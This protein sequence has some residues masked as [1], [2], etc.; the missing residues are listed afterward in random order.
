MRQPQQKAYALAGT[1]SVNAGHY[2]PDNDKVAFNAACLKELN[3]LSQQPVSDQE[4]DEKKDKVAKAEATAAALKTDRDQH[5]ATQQEYVEDTSRGPLLRHQWIDAAASSILGI[6]ALVIP[7]YLM[8][9]T[10]DEIG[11]EFFEEK[12]AAGPLI[13]M[14]AAT[15]GMAVAALRNQFKFEARERY[16]TVVLGSTV[17]TYLGSLWIGASVAMTGGGSLTSSFSLNE[18]HVLFSAGLLDACAG[19]SLFIIRHHLFGPHYKTVNVVQENRVVLA[20]MIEAADEAVRELKG[21]LSALVAKNDEWAQVQ[22][23]ALSMVDEQYELARSRFEY[24]VA[25]TKL[26]ITQGHGPEQSDGLTTSPQKPASTTNGSPY[27]A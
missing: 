25:K 3:G 2:V 1:V 24:G 22:A 15:G 23:L 11:L 12:A 19:G 5:P 26:D 17:I 14:L 20:P 7:M 9:A 21:E 6:A 13:S 18:A 16:D 8:N 4:I 27:H 10:L